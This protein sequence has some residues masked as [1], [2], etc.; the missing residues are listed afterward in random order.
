MKGWK[1]DVSRKFLGLFP[2]GDVPEAISM[3]LSRSFEKAAEYKKRFHFSMYRLSHPQKAGVRIAIDQEDKHIII[4][5]TEEL[6]PDLQEFKP[7][8]G[9]S[10]QAPKWSAEQWAAA[11]EAIKLNF[12]HQRVGG[13]PPP[14]Q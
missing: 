10:F 9:D 5:L 3:L 7:E 1:V 2:D 12:S 13:T 14:K 6:P 4:L 8:P 11:G